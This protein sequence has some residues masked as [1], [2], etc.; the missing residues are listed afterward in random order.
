MLDYRKE[1][2]SVSSKNSR[3]P[4]RWLLFLPA[5]KQ[6]WGP[7]GRALRGKSIGGKRFPAGGRLMFPQNE[8]GLTGARS[9]EARY[10]PTT[11]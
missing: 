7:E 9:R 3:L 4:P 8:A 5:K 1:K 11:E 10:A 2:N 6:A